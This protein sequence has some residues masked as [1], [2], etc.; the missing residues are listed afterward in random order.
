MSITKERMAEVVKDN[1]RSE[2]DTGSVEVQVAIMTERI[3]NLSTHLKNNNLK[4]F[5]TRRGLLMMVT[6]RRKLVRYLDKNDP[7]R[8]EALRKKLGLRK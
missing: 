3:N 1:S 2:K 7:S 4:D 8:A 5:Q 6:R